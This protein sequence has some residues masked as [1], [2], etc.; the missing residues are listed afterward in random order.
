MTQL[1]RLFGSALVGASL[2]TLSASAQ[3]QDMDAMLDR[4][5]ELLAEQAIDLDWDD[6]AIDGDSAVLTGVTAAGPEGETPL[7][8]IV[9]SG[10]SETA[11]GFRIDEM[12]MENYVH[13]EEDF[14][15]E[16]DGAV[17]TGI[18][19][20]SEEAAEDDRF[21]GF[22][23]YETADIAE[24][25]ASMAGEEVFV[26]NGLN[27]SVS[28]LVAD[29]PMAFSA[30]AENF[31]ADLTGIEDEMTRQTLR[32]LGYEQVTGRLESTGSW[33]PE[34]GRLVLD[35]NDLTIDDGGT[36]GF[37]LDITGYTAE[38]M[39]ALSEVQRTM[40][41]R[42]GDAAG[43]MAAMGLMQQL[44]L[45]SADIYFRDDALTGRVLE[46]FAED[47]GMRPQDVV[48]Q[49]KAILPF[50]LAQIG[51][52]QLGSMI[53]GAVSEYL[54]NPQSLRV[55]ARPAEPVPFSLLMAGAMASPQALA[56]QI[57]LEVVAN[58]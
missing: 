46:L 6:A 50:L 21:G 5:Q 43:G 32:R 54:D 49:A 55:S 58:D 12:S 48:N 22:F 28:P 1:K 18:I 14:S 53:S 11:D 2:I 40:Q 36:I 27:V 4:L 37:A 15:L 8:D 25:R 29:Q 47:Q 34:D 57:G 19:L 52:P 20:P 9:I 10:V 42:E 35:R 39:R 24:L 33:T 7:G 16:I 13:G 51:A 56:D 30:T 31:E 3:A 44:N 45:A 41:D 26:L 38:F 23:Y 17:L